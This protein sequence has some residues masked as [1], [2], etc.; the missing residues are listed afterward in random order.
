MGDRTFMRNQLTYSK[1]ACK[2]RITQEAIN[3]LLPFITK[4]KI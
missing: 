2:Y 1:V 4:R 3:N